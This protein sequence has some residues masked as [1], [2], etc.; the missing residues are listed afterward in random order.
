[1]AFTF[2]EKHLHKLHRIFELV[3]CIYILFCSLKESAILREHFHQLFHVSDL[4]VIADRRS[5]RTKSFVR[6]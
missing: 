2:K 4:S 5:E 3:F 6:I 1:M